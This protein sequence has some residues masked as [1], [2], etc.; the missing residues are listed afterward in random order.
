VT[1]ADIRGEKATLVMIL[2]NHCPFVIMLKPAIAK[3]VKEYQAR[4]VGAVGISA[5]STQTHPQDAPDKMAVDAEEQGY[6][7]PYLYDESQG[8]AQVPRHTLVP[9]VLVRRA[10]LFVGAQESRLPS[11]AIFPCVPS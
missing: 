9:L 3:L 10:Y 11:F 5:S 4:G 2:S 7:F 8:T 6:T 1:F